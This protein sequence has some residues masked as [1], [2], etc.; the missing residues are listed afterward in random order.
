M[1]GRRLWEI[2]FAV[3]AVA[4]V[5]TTWT[6]TASSTISGSC[7]A[8]NDRNYYVCYLAT[9]CAEMRANGATRK[10]WAGLNF[11]AAPWLLIVARST[12][13]TLA[14]FILMYGGFFGGLGI[15]FPAGAALLK[16]P[17][18]PSFNSDML[19]GLVNIVII[20]GISTLVSLRVAH[21]E[22]GGVMILLTYTVL[23]GL[24][25]V[26]YHAMLNKVALKTGYLLLAALSFFFEMG[27]WIDAALNYDVLE[28]PYARGMAWNYFFMTLSAAAWVLEA[29]GACDVTLWTLLFP[30]SGMFLA[31]DHIANIEA[32]K[33]APDIVLE[34]AS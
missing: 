8:A 19:P 28:T 14:R 23:W 4:A 12:G 25:M 30:G 2:V 13:N 22:T 5:Y 24:C 31:F 34:L 21:V 7:A 9:L 29:C 6:A 17:A 3:L 11:A 1:A 15:F 27:F 10:A 32:K 33:A 20:G 16:P 18:A 26:L